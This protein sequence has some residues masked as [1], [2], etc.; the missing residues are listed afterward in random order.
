MGEWRR[1]EAY[2]QKLSDD[3]LLA[4]Y[5]EAR[6]NWMHIL[7]SDNPNSKNYSTEYHLETLGFWQHIME[8][9]ERLLTE[10][11]IPLHD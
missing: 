9:T 5:D 8:L 10:R 11:D 6:G 3:E 2:Y 7:A 4:R 1:N